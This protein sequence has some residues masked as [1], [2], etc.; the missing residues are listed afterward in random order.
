MFIPLH[1]VS[2]SQVEFIVMRGL[3]QCRSHTIAWVITRYIPLH[4]VGQSQVYPVP[5]R[6]LVEKVASRMLVISG[7]LV[8]VILVISGELVLGMLESG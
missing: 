7:E 1:R 6:T 2:Q 4:C 3:E 8:V 5:G